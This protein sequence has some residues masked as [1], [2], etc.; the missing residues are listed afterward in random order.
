[1]DLEHQDDV[2]I[3]DELMRCQREGFVGVNVTHPYKSSAYLAVNRTV[4]MPGGLTAVNTVMFADGGWTGANTDCSGFVRAFRSGFGADAPPGRV[5]M[6]GAGGV[7]KAI[8]F[9]LHE[10][11][12]DELVI[13]DTSPAAI[14]TLLTELSACGQ[15]AHKADDLASEMSRA[16]GLVNASPIGMYQYPG[17]VFPASKLGS[18]QWAFDAVYTP[19]LTEF[20][21]AC[22]AGGIP[23]LSGFKLFLYQGL[24]AWRHFTG[25]PADAGTIERAFLRR[26]APDG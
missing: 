15:R 3:A 16:D 14:Q 21:A 20:M 12:A 7:G 2:S 8:A 13:H 1:M 4:S 10:L 25:L 19:E 18:Q 26:Y 17:S 11:G 5:L 22:K 24:D 9:A 6:V 23:T